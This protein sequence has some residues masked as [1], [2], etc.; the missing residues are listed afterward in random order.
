ME[1]LNNYTQTFEQHVGRTYKC[2]RLV[3]RDGNL[4]VAYNPVK[5]SIKDKLKEVS[6]KLKTLPDGVYN[7]QCQY[8]HNKATAPDNLLI[9]KGSVSLSENTPIILPGQNKADKKETDADIYT[10]K[11]TMSR[12][13]EIANLRAESLFLKAENERLKKEVAE[14]ENEIQT[15]EMETMSDRPSGIMS[16]LSGE[17]SPLKSLA[18]LIPALSDSYFKMKDR[19]LSL[20][21]KQIDKR[22]PVNMADRR[23][24]N[25]SQT[26][27]QLDLS[28][29]EQLNKHFSIMEGL[30]DPEFAKE[31]QRSK[32]EQPDLFSATCQEF[33]LNE[34]GEAI[35]ENEN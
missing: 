25:N 29:G 1:K 14:L 33:G 9:K 6:R 3:D 5:L 18:E 27:G 20:R 28:D 31:L 22:R 13:E 26:M 16:L 24:K 23:F 8:S 15:A 17:N 2:C 10:V 11:A 32:N 19:E 4:L 7:L 21:E 34:N 30:S 12:I 35:E